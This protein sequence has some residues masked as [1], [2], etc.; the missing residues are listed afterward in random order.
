MDLPAG[1]RFVSREVASWKKY[2][3]ETGVKPEQ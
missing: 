1:K 3:E 2:V